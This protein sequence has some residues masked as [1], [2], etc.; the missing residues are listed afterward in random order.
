[1]KTRL[2]LTLTA[3]IL[4]TSGL[5]A[6]PADNFKA[7]GIGFGGDL[8]LHTSFDNFANDYEE[9]KQTFIHLSISPSFQFFVVDIISIHTSQKFR[10]WL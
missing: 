3:A 2:I 5:F 8:S 4:V 10:L 9:N 7:A 6:D 1:M